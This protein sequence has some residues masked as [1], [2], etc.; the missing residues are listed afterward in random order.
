MPFVF[1]PFRK[2]RQWRG[3]GILL[4]EFV[5]LIAGVFLGLQAQDWAEQRTDRARERQYLARVAADFDDILEE[6]RICLGIYDGSIEAI[7]RVRGTLDDISAG[8]ID[9]VPQD[10]DQSLLRITA[11]TMPP[12]RS[13]AYVEMISA[14]ELRLIRND[15]LRASLVRYDQQTIANRVIWRTL[16]DSLTPFMP[17]VL[18]Y[19]DVR[20][21]H[22][23]VIVSALEV[24]EFAAD[25]EARVA[26]RAFIATA[27]NSHQLCE[28]QAALAR[29][30]VEALPGEGSR[31]VAVAP[32]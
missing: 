32:D 14:G 8:R 11:G 21:D 17:I 6:S 15:P 23:S 24:N 4:L 16:R 1:R 26:L 27:T 12:G 30:V 5:V 3:L 10:F 7:E 22:Q 25:P 13:S 9:E 19:I 28:R 29:L 31:V 2:R 18:R 20:N